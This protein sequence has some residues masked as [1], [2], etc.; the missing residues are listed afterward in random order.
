[1]SSQE[2]HVFTSSPCDLKERKHFTCPSLKIEKKCPD[3]TVLETN[4][5]LAEIYVPINL[6]VSYP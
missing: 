5:I 4:G 1:M 3:N 6:M 2:K